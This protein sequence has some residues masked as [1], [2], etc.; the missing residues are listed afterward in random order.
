M[1]Y[2]PKVLVRGAPPSLYSQLA[3]T[4]EIQ[5]AR[6]TGEMQSEVR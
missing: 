2:R 6:E 5:F 4:P 1:K 3:D